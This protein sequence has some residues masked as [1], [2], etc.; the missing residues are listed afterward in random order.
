M[1]AEV[2]GPNA[3]SHSSTRPATPSASGRGAIPSPSHDSMEA[4]RGREVVHP[5]SF[6]ARTICPAADSV[7]NTRG[8]TAACPPQDFPSP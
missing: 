5:P 2:P 6:E 4:H 3:R 7:V 8:P 1:S